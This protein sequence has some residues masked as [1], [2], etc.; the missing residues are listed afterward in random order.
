MYVTIKVVWKN[1]LKAFF[2]KTSVLFFILVAATMLGYT[3]E[4]ITLS[5]AKSQNDGKVIKKGQ[6]RVYDSYTHDQLVSRIN[7]QKAEALQKVSL[8]KSEFPLNAWANHDDSLALVALFDSTNGPGWKVKTNWKIGRVSS[9]H[10]V[11]LNG[12]GRVYM[13]DLPSN[14]LS[15]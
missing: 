4:P 3:T 12:S 2:M 15:G 8:L 11:Y 1:S 14:R 9:W 5:P 13:V 6:I 7:K 10:N